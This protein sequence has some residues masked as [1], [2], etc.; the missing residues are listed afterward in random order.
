MEQ[1]TFEEA[2]K[3]KYQDLLD[4]LQPEHRAQLEA[5]IATYQESEETEEDQAKLRREVIR[6][7]NSYGYNELAQA[8]YLLL[9]LHLTAEYAAA[10]RELTLEE[11]INRLLRTHAANDLY[12]KR[13]RRFWMV[14]TVIMAPLG[15]LIYHGIIILT[16]SLGGVWTIAIGLAA[17]ALMAYGLMRLLDHPQSSGL[18]RPVIFSKK[19]KKSAQKA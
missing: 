8:V 11:D 19:E 3:G 9:M 12:F 6:M 13:D 18:H 10:D 4:F 7:C 15:G 16:A 5:A 14:M 17:A 2:A 1:P